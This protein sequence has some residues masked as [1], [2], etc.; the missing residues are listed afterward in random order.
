MR[1]E[2]RR[3]QERVTFEREIRLAMLRQGSSGFDSDSEKA[4]DDFVDNDPDEWWR[5]LQDGKTPKE[6]VVKKPEVE[7]RN[8]ADGETPKK[9]EGAAAEPKV[10][11]RTPDEANRLL[12]AFNPVH[13]S[14]EKLQRLLYFR[15]DPNS[16]PTLPHGMSPLHKINIYALDEDVTQ[17]RRLLLV[18]GATET[19]ADKERLAQRPDINDATRKLQVFRPVRE[20]TEALK[21]L[22]DLRADPYGIVPKPPDSISP[23]LNVKTDL[24]P[25]RTCTPRLDP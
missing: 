1:A 11:F 17:M 13:E 4:E 10:E 20:N 9:G 14:V 22:V 8:S 6:S 25:D 2:A 16:P 19:E 12:H 3:I 7:T 24:K 15:A 5:D 21:S 23:L 18:Y